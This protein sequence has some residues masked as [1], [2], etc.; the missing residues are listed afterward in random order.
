[1]KAASLRRWVSLPLAIAITFVVQGTRGSAQSSKPVNPKAPTA[2]PVSE[3]YRQVS[4]EDGIRFYSRA[5]SVELLGDG[6]LQEE[7]FECGVIGDDGKEI[8]I[9][10]TSTTTDHG[11]IKT[12]DFGVLKIMGANGMRTK[13]F[14]TESQIKKLRVL[15]SVDK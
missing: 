7:G 6:T 1:M 9:A 11:R 14:A 2:A 13:L 4:R 3:E 5:S 8:P 12:K 15:Q 10:L